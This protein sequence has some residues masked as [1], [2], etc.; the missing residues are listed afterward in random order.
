[1]KITDLKAYQPKERAVQPVKEAAEPPRPSLVG[2][3]TITG[4]VRE[5]DGAKV[6]LWDDP[7]C[8][9]FYASADVLTQLKAAQ[10]DALTVAVTVEKL[11]GKWTA[12]KVEK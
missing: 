2:P 9:Q 10:Y 8:R 12:T 11:R 3:E 6:M 5:I 7:L 4:C 1:M